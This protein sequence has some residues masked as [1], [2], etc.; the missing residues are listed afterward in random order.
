M[1]NK[2]EELDGGPFREADEMFSRINEILRNA[3]QQGFIELEIDPNND[4]LKKYITEA[5][6]VRIKLPKERRQ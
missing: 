3:E 5:V 2:S 1:C 6:K 4:F